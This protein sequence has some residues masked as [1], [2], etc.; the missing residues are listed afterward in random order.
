M[1]KISTLV[2][3]IYECENP[4]FQRR[5]IPSIILPHTFL[6]YF[7]LIYNN[8]KWTIL[9]EEALCGRERD[10]VKIRGCNFELKFWIKVRINDIL[11]AQ[12]Q[13]IWNQSPTLTRKGLNRRCPIYAYFRVTRFSFTLKVFSHIAGLKHKMSCIIEQITYNGLKC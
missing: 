11:W 4:V 9:V 3:F 5:K 6:V 10:C 1:N 8:K 12:K 2:K 7:Y 13:Y